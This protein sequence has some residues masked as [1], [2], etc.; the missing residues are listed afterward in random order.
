MF[1]GN[2]S[3]TPANLTAP[4]VNIYTQLYSMPFMKAFLAFRTIYYSVLILLGVFGNIMTFAIIRRFKSSWSATDR[5]FLSLA[6]TDLCVVITSMFPA[7]SRSASGFRIKGSHVVV[8]KIFNSVYNIS[9]ASSC[10]ILAAM[11]IHRA[12]MVVWPHRVNIICT[13]RR[14]W[15]AIIAIIIYS[16]L[17]FSH[18]FY[19]LTVVPQSGGCAAIGTYRKFLGNKSR[20]N[21]GLSFFGTNLPVLSP[22][23]RPLR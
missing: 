9:V 23:P 6:V 1:L 8:C 2:T 17:T 15:F 20:F 22:C 16:C 14:S 18:M 11:A 21:I 19:G 3:S 5:Y 7:W 4:S 12:L 10:W 13:P